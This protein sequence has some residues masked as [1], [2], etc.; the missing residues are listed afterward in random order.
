MTAAVIALG[1]QA[2]ELLVTIQRG[3]DKT[4]ALRLLDG[5]T[6][7]TDQHTARIEY[8]STPTVWDAEVEEVDGSDALV[9]RLDEDDTDLA[10]GQ[11]GARLVI[12]NGTN[13]TVLGIGR[14]V[15]E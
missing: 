12:T 6:N 8:G 3:A 2:A 14:V 9:W 11:Y 1:A 13:D 4:F 10:A 15:V 7:V 5:E